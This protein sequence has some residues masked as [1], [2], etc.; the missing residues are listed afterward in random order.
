MLSVT[1]SVSTFE[2]GWKWRN[3]QKDELLKAWELRCCFC[4][5]RGRRIKQQLLSS[6]LRVFV[7]EWPRIWIPMRFPFFVLSYYFFVSSFRFKDDMKEIVSLVLTEM[8]NKSKA[9]TRIS[10]C[11]LVLENNFFLLWE[12]SWVASPVPWEMW[13]SHAGIK[14]C[15]ILLQRIQIFVCFEFSCRVHLLFFFSPIVALSE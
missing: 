8:Q 15:Y 9:E 14:Q 6:A 7:M 10:D 5:R 4:L 13:E 12:V 2:E 11:E 1:Q 3:F